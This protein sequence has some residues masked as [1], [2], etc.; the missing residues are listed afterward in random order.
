MHKMQT[1][2]YHF[3]FQ[4][5]H[6]SLDLLLTKMLTCLCVVCGK[7]FK[8]KRH[9]TS[10][11]WT[12]RP[13]PVGPSGSDWNTDICFFQLEP[14]VWVQAICCST[15][16]AVTELFLPVSSARQRRDSGS[17]RANPEQLKVDRHATRQWVH[18]A[19]SLPAIQAAPADV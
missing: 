3:D 5:C 12:H 19:A 8:N 2:I 11:I 7:K 6:Y 15:S 9:V 16:P 13:P 1:I 18:S 4:K 17:D 14:L 10:N